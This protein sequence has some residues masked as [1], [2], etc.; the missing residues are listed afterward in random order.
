M[1][2]E[3]VGTIEEAIITKEAGI[4]NSLL[5]NKNIR[6]IEISVE[7]NFVFKYD[8]KYFEH[9]L[10][11]NEQP[12]IIPKADNEYAEIVKSLSKV[13]F[14]MRGDQQMI[15]RNT[16]ITPDAEIFD[17]ILFHVGKMPILIDDDG[18]TM[19]FNDA[20]YRLVDG[21]VD[22]KPEFKEIIKDL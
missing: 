7:E 17:T 9:Q 11:E 21:V 16:V 12:L 18:E 3:N 8:S 20:Y 15:N 4:L 13:D 6:G 19:W 2:V 10:V 14:E 22:L 1:K 5:R